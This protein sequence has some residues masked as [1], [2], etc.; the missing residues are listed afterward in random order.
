VIPLVA[1]LATP[2]VLPSVTRGGRRGCGCR[3]DCRLWVV[4]RGR[5]SG[6]GRGCCRL[7]VFVV[8]VVV[9]VDWVAVPSNGRR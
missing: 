9:V 8:A 2:S 1:T 3:R 5:G 7:H 4:G 6:R